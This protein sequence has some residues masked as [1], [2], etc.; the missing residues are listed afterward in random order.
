[1]EEFPSLKLYPKLSLLLQ[2]LLEK[3]K[4]AKRSRTRQMRVHKY[5]KGAR[6]IARALNDVAE[7]RIPFEAPVIYA[8]FVRDFLLTRYRTRYDTARRQNAASRLAEKFANNVGKED[9]LLFDTVA[10]PFSR[11][12]K[13]SRNDKV[14]SR[15][16]ISFRSRS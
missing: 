4:G 7:P 2:S 10:S 9:V 14:V 11:K 5:A 13:V 6:P 8:P 12:R 15:V 3:G 1:M 16:K